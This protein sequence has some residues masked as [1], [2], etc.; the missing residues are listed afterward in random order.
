MRAATLRGYGRA[1][2][3]DTRLRRTRTATRSSGRCAGAAGGGDFWAWRDD[4]DRARRV[5]DRRR[6]PARVRPGL[7]GAAR[8][9]LHGG[10]RVPLPRARGGA[11]GGRGRR[12]GRASSSSAST[13]ATCAAAVP[14]SARTRSAE[15]LRQLEAAARR[16]DPRRCRPPLRARVPGRRARASS[17]GTPTE[18]DLPLHVHAD[19]QPREIEECLAEHGLRPI[20]L[21]DAHRLSR[22]AVDDRARHA[23]RRPRA[24]PAARRRRAHLRVPDDRGEPRRRLPPGRARLPPRDRT[25]HRL[26]LERAHRPARGA[27]RAR[28]HRTPPDRQA[29]RHLGRHAALLRLGRGRSRA[30]PRDVARRR[31]RPRPRRS[32]AASPRQTST[33]ASCSAAPATVLRKTSDQ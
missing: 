13:R 26:R 17:G 14:A 5:A 25:V 23:C 32:C 2:A 21:L 6:D 3:L 8:E 31:G 30:R 10:R 11:R 9:R 27:T 16:R 19:E 1:D 4:D 28:G 24:R 15:Y 20:E 22:P 33:T 12:R 29:R 18:H 7:P